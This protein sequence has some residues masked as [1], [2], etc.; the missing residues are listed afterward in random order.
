[1]RKDQIKNWTCYRILLW[2]VLL[3]LV[4]AC[5]MTGP[6]GPIGPQS[7]LN[8]EE[9][10]LLLGDDVTDNAKD[11]LVRAQIVIDDKAKLRGRLVKFANDPN[12][13]LGP[14][15]E[16]V[17]NKNAN[18]A[19]GTNPFKGLGGG[20]Y[21]T[22]LRAAKGKVGADSE[23]DAS[24]TSTV[25]L[26]GTITDYSFSRN[27]NK[28]SG[29]L[30]VE[31]YQTVLHDGGIVEV[32]NYVW[33]IEINPNGYDIHTHSGNRD[34]PFPGT[35]FF[36]DDMLDRIEDRGFNVKLH[37]SGPG[38]IKIKNVEK[39]GFDIEP[40]DPQ[41][42]HLLQTSQDDCIDIFLKVETDANG[43]PI[44]DEIP[45]TYVELMA[46]EYSYCLGRCANPAIVNS[47]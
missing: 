13:K 21:H 40:S 36:D 41:Y 44:L 31:T 46:D 22:L 2:P 4:S 20:Y 25:E 23:Y 8:L 10:Y 18:T 6:P 5:Q 29:E 24:R 47:R 43:D 15:I 1:M 45:E 32:S 27:G 30:T 38:A 28:G 19:G 33:T 35:L 34:D 39:D 12:K 37:A 11:N 42:G 26:S 17:R 9:T 16:D 3:V 14:L 7:L